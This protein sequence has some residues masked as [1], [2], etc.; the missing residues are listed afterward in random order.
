[1][2]NALN[3]KILKENPSFSNTVNALKTK[4]LDLGFGPNFWILAYFMATYF[5]VNICYKRPMHALANQ[6]NRTFAEL[7]SL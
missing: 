6:L 1:M 4:T 7:V 3:F 5:K 2:R